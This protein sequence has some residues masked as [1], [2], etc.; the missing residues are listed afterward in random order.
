M[1]LN[2]YLICI[3]FTRGSTI[4]RIVQ[5][6]RSVSGIIQLGG[7]SP[8]IVQLGGEAPDGNI[9]LPLMTKGERFIRC[10]VQ[11]HGSRGSNGHRG[12]MSDMTLV[13]H[14]S[15]SINAKGGDC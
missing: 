8:R 12:S 10:R 5:V 1:L 9:S 4:K 7:V 14:Q 2:Y 3:I 15:V 13:L 11:S 6:K